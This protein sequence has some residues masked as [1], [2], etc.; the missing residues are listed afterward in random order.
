M[1]RSD[2][3]IFIK[4]E[5]SPYGTNAYVFICP[6]T[7]KSVLIDAP[8]E[9]ERIL[10]LLQET[11][12]QS[13]LITHSHFDHI[14]ALKELKSTLK[15]P[16][17]CHSADFKRLPISPDF[18]LKDDDKITVGKRQLK[19]IHTP[20]HTPGS[21]CFLHEEILFSG[22]TIFPGGPGRTDSPDDFQLILKSL[23]EKIFVLPDDTNVH[24]GHGDSTILKR[25]KEEFAQFA[26][27]SH[28]PHLCGN[29][30]WLS[31]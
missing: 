4:L 13:I 17:G 21:L 5:T 6:E 12:L 3:P 16:V 19:V 22:D 10:Q 1:H 15:A 29:I 14:G 31:S 18:E 30:L 9:T 2:Q 28:S 25:E 23:Q 8:G 20:G 26:S 7:K 24:P 27:R 11:D